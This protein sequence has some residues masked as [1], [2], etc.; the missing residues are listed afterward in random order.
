MRDLSQLAER[1][2]DVLVIGAGIVG[3][4]IANE[5]ARAGL[6]VALVDRGDFGAATSSAS[7]KLIH[8]GLRYLRLGDVKLVREARRERR[9]LLETVAPYLVRK[10]PFLFP[11]YRDGPYRPNTLRLGRVYSALAEDRSAACCRPRA[12]CRASPT[13]GSRACAAAVSTSTRS[14]TMRG[15]V[16]Q[17][18]GGGRRRRRSRELRGSGRAPAGGRSCPRRRAERS[19][20]GRD[21]LRRSSHGGERNRPLDRTDPRPR[22]SGGGAARGPVE[23]RAPP[24]RPRPALVGG[25]DDPARP[26]AR[27]VRIPLAGEAAARDDG[28]ALRGRPGGRRRRA[29]RR[30]A[31]ARRGVGRSRARGPRSGSRPGQLRRIA[32]APRPVGRDADRAAR[33]GVRARPRRHADRGRGEV[34]DLPP[35][36]ARRTRAAAA[37]ARFAAVRP[38][39]GAIAGRARPRGGGPRDRRRFPALDPATRSH[40]LHLYGSLAEDVLAPASDEPSLLEPIHPD[41]PDVLA[42]IGYAGEQEW[43]VSVD[44]SS[45][46]GPRWVIAASR[47]P[48]PRGGGVAR[49][50]RDDGSVSG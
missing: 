25:A 4:G 44:E 5:V 1:Q 8:G 46:G 33:D 45:G 12:R 40:L 38:A 36:F 15:S 47:M 26:G 28:H 17:C 7:S 2:F 50:P 43:A 18:P 35:D 24:P 22:G 39:A 48:P 10:L 16:S 37:G 13:S 30:R 6:A 41:A 31:R 32:G 42:Q 9:A 3:A 27:H 19:P 49:K 11:L 23:G 21:G 34:D 20:V 14:R 29:C